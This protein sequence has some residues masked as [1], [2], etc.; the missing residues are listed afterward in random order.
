VQH[1]VGEQWD[2]GQAI[3]REQREDSDSDQQHPHDRLPACVR[4]T[5][6]DPFEPSLLM[7]IGHERG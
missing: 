4:G 1:L 2:Q 5:L 3:H 7:T 6:C